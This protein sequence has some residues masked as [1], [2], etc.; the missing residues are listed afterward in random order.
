MNTPQFLNSQIIEI[1]S[2]KIDSTSKEITMLIHKIDHVNENGLDFLKPYV[3]EHMNSLLNKPVV[4]KYNAIKDDLGGHE[5][6][7]DKKTGKII[8]LR[9]I[10]IGT[11]TDVWIDKMS[12]DEDAIEAL[13]AKAT[14]WSYKYPKIMTCI[15]KLHNDD[16]SRSSVEI[17]IYQYGDNPTKEYRFATDYAYIGQCLLG[18]Q[19]E[20]AD[21]DAGVLS[22]GDKEIAM[23]IEEDLENIEA[24]E[25]GDVNVSDQT[26]PLFNK[27]IEINFHGNFE[28]NSLKW[29]DVSNSIYNQLNPLNPQTNERKYNYY[30]RDLFVDHVIVEDWNDYHTLYRIGYAISGD[31]VILD[32]KDK[33][34]QG[35]KGFIPNG[36]NIDELIASKQTEV[37][38]LQ[39]EHDKIVTELNNK[40][41]QLQEEAK[42]TMEKTVDE[43]KQELST[44]DTEIST[45]STKVTE[46]DTKIAE[47]SAT[48]VSQEEAKKGFETQITEL[49]STIADLTTYKEQFETAQKEAKK[50]ELSE[51]FS[52]LLSTEVFSSE[53]VQK[54]LEELSETELNSVVV[55]EIAKEKSVEVNNK[56]EVVVVVASKQEDLIPGDKKSYWYSTKSE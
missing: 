22:I 42:N 48:I 27:G 49:N 8:E 15:E 16:S 14:I 51:K 19:I 9:T 1:S 38:Q 50:T 4:C 40:L 34:I 44:K 13:Y 41:T 32:E 6:V 45:L 54:A 11:I 24:I 23:A 53:R 31:S 2:S 17:E 35:H 46:L 33:W 25:K 12:E 21:T 39:S 52:K 5:Q 18:S 3:E 28:V 43:L 56:K 10:A 26:Q 29:K 7:I 55:E 30:I 47:L 37:N 36:V 20:P